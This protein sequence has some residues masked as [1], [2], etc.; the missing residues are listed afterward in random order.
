MIPHFGWETVVFLPQQGTSCLSW[1]LREDQRLQ[2]LSCT[3]RKGGPTPV[4]SHR[5]DSDPAT[6]HF[7]ASLTGTSDL[8][9]PDE[10][11]LTKKILFAFTGLWISWHEAPQR[12]AVWYKQSHGSLEIYL[13]SW[14]AD[15]LCRPFGVLCISR[16]V[17]SLLRH[18]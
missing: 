8:G 15:K 2:R 10:N 5:R 11:L 17:V 14:E 18:A 4:G 12:P 3:V 13:S 9:N 16:C 6:P 7:S 1:Y